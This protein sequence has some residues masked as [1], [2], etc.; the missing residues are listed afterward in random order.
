MFLNKKGDE[1]ASLNWIIGTLAG[2]LL[3]SVIVTVGIQWYQTTTTTEDSFETLVEKINALQDKQ[4]DSMAYSLPNDYLLIS[5][6]GEKDFSNPATIGA[7]S[8]TVK[9]PKSCGNAPC[10]CVCDASSRTNE[11]ACRED[12]VVCHPFTNQPYS[13][14]DTE[15]AYGVYRE[16]PDNGIFSL[17]LQRGG[18]TIKFCTTESCVP[19]EYEAAVAATKAVL[20]EWKACQEKSDCACELELA[21]FEENENYALIF[22][23]D[24]AI[25]WDISRQTEVYTET[26]GTDVVLQGHEQQKFPFHALAEVSSTGA[27]ISTYFVVDQPA[28]PDTPVQVA[29]KIFRSGSNMF[30]VDPA[31]DFTAIPDCE[32]QQTSQDFLA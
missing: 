16:G 7:C 3:A 12:P 27:I 5:F 18:N 2:V 22:Q 10:L 32:S 15:C 9:I 29:K 17:F 28:V 25:L 4:S 14:S 19:E 31:Y 30:F 23:S 20:T 21:Y 8:G 26:F 11:L 24:K 13:F 6:T 1:T